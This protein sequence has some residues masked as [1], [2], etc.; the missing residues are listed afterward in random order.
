MAAEIRVPRLGWSMEEGTFLGWK[1][2]A[3]EIVTVGEILYE[4]EGEKAT[5]EI[6]SLDAGVLHIAPT[7]PSPG[8]VLPVGALLG[9]VAAAGESVSWP[10][11]AEAQAPAAKP[12]PVAESRPPASH[13]APSVRRRAREL[14]VSIDELLPQPQTGRVKQRDVQVSAKVEL[15]A[16]LPPAAPAGEIKASPRA[17]RAARERGID[18]RQLAGSGRNGRICERDVLAVAGIAAPIPGENSIPITARRRTIAQRMVQSLERTAPVTLTTRADVTRLVE[19]RAKLKAAG[20]DVVPAYGDLIAQLVAITLEKHTLLAGRWEESRIVLPR[21]GHIHLGIAVD[22]EEGLLVPVLRDVAALSIDEIVR[23]SRELAEKARANKLMVAEMQGAVFTITNLGAFGIDAF[24]PIIHWPQTAILGLGAI[25]R[26]PNFVE[27]DRIES[28]HLMTLS[29][30]FDHRV[31]DGAP[32][33][34]FLADL[35]AAIEQL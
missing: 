12:A 6:E 23:Q 27:N 29:L 9:C 30:T 15:I 19:L 35:V 21:P 18:W 7:C 5:Q 28:R 26:E 16:S 2:Q 4:L 8:T 20:S 31:I 33:A 17:R 22:T 14:G 25:R 34:R 24:T 11:A 13:A 32:A 10:A 3:G 1:K